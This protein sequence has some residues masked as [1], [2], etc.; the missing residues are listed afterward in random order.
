MVHLIESRKEGGGVLSL[1]LLVSSS[2]CTYVECGFVNDLR[3]VNSSFG[4]DVIFSVLL[5]IIL[6]RQNSNETFLVPFSTLCFI[7]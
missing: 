5:G 7:K 2:P 6:P 1:V 3:F 4:F